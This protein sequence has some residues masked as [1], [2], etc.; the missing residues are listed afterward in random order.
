VVIINDGR[1]VVEGV[2]KDLKDAAPIR[3]LEIELDEST[4]DLLQSLDGVV[5]VSSRGGTQTAI[6]DANTDVRGV[7]LKAQEAGTIRHFTY[8]SPSLTDLFREA[9]K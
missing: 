9:I 4:E 1:I 8:A 5:R 7:L 2:V 6:I 3:H